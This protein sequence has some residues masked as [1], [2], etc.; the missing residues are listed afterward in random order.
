MTTARFKISNSPGKQFT[1][2]LTGANG[3]IMLVSE[4]HTS[5]GGAMNGIDSVKEN[6]LHDERY[7]RLV[8]RDDQ[9]QRYF[10]L[11]AANGEVLAVSEMYSSKSAMEAG[12]ASVK[13]HAPSAIVE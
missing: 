4:R 3:E 8:S 13:A 9:R 5:H 12:I 6:A 2:H 10:V 1:F 11:K 7:D